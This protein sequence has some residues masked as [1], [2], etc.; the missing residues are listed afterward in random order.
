MTRKLSPSALS[1]FLKSPKAFYWRYRANLEPIGQSVVTFDHDKLAG[2]IWSAAVDRFYNGVPEAQNALQTMNEWEAGTDGWVPEKAKQKLTGALGA[3]VSNYYQQFS[4]DDGCRAPNQSELWAE[5]DRFRGRLDGLSAERVVHEVKSTSRSPNLTDQLWKVQN[6]L[7]VRLYCV[8]AEANGHCVE[9]AFKD[10]P[11]AIFRGPV[12]SVSSEQRR[13]WELELNTLADYINSLGDDP[14]NYACNPDGCCL[15]T[16]GMTSMCAY[17]S[18][19]DMGLTE[20][21]KIA[22]KDREYK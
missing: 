15:V 22:Y 9:F 3:W 18:L 16:K 4:P 10:P 13:A 12:V 8:L 1:T 6:S 19:C 14:N 20:E 2:Q 17:Q 5:N 7:Q 21:T 11:H